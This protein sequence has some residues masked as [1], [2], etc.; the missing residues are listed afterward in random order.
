M[1]PSGPPVRIQLSRRRG[2]R[3]QEASLA[4]NGRQAVKV[5]RTSRWGNPYKVGETKYEAR[6]AIECVA[7][8]RAAMLR[9]QSIPTKNG[10]GT[11][12]AVLRAEARSELAGKNIACW[13][14]PKSPCHGD[15]WLEIANAEPAK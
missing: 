2:F 13:C 9:S 12:T 15:V 1:T 5:D 4:I 8:F 7:M 14:D 3:L 11:S 6:T 10:S